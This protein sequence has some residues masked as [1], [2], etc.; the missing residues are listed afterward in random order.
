MKRFFP[1]LLLTMPVSLTLANPPP[2]WDKVIQTSESPED[3]AV[4]D[5]DI[6]TVGPYEDL[7]NPGSNNLVDDGGIDLPFLVA[8]KGFRVYDDPNEQRPVLENRSKPSKNSATK[9][10][11]GVVCEYQA[12]WSLLR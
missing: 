1:Y 6:N 2:Q 5:N 12:Y 8:E 11:G 4:Q 3:F 9:Y 10:T 7:P